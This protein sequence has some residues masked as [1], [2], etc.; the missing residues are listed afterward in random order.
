MNFLR[1]WGFSLLQQFKTLHEMEIWGGKFLPGRW[2]SAGHRGQW[3]G[4]GPGPV[5]S[6][7]SR[8]GTRLHLRQKKARGATETPKFLHTPPPPS[9][10][11]GPYLARQVSR[12]QR[13]WPSCLVV[14]QPPAPRCPAVGWRQAAA[15]P[16]SSAASPA[17]KK[18]IRKLWILTRGRGMRGF[19]SPLAISSPRCLSFSL[20]G[21]T[22]KIAE[23]GIFQVVAVAKKDGKKDLCFAK[24]PLSVFPKFVFF[25]QPIF[26]VRKKERK[27][28]AW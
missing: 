17:E 4:R 19:N 10:P 9:L 3:L 1:N 22:G 26:P 16:V 24:L 7:L 21:S 12:C 20:G 13:S 14:A 18:K 23:K 27:K 25:V 6:P 2:G 28:R 8:A 15:P 11:Q 5:T